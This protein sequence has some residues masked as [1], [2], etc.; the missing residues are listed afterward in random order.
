MPATT[1]KQVIAIMLPSTSITAS[2]C[3]KNGAAAVT[4][5]GQ[6]VAASTLT[7][8]AALAALFGATAFLGVAANIEA[9]QNI[10]TASTNRLIVARLVAMPQADT[11]AFT[12]TSGSV[13]TGQVMDV[14]AFAD[15]GLIADAEMAVLVNFANA[16]QGALT[17]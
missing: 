8:P 10:V 14:L 11:L 6:T 1:K 16:V 3:T 7:T 15:S 13:Y 17:T 12:L 5:T 4:K 2:S 9:V